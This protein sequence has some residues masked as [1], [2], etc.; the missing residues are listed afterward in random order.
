MT[1]EDAAAGAAAVV[2]EVPQE[3]EAHPE[4]EV[5]VVGNRAS[6]EAPRSLL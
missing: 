2:G 3:A 5:A 4:E 6:R 1:V